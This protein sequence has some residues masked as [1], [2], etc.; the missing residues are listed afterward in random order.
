MTVGIRADAS[1]TF[2]ALTLNGADQLRFGSDNSGA[3]AGFRNRIINGDMRVA[4]RGITTFTAG[5]FPVDRWVVEANVPGGATFNSSQALDGGLSL[6]GPAHIYIQTTAAGAVGAGNFALLSQRMEGL[7]VANF[8]FGTSQAKTITLSFRAFATQNVTM[9]V[10]IRNGGSSRSYVS[11]VA[12]TTT[13][14]SYS[15]VIPGDTTDTWSTDTNTGMTVSFCHSAGTTFQTS[16]LNA[17]QAG[18]FIAANTQTQLFPVLNGAISIGDVQLEVGSI[19]TPFEVRQCGA[20]LALCQ[21]YYWRFVGATGNNSVIGTGVM[22][23]TTTAYI[24]WNMPVTMRI[25]PIVSSLGTIGMYDGS[26]V[27][28]LSGLNND[29]STVDRV[30]RDYT[31]AAA[32]ILGRPALLVVRNGAYIEHNAE[33]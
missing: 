16:T 28:N 31:L 25:V 32:L 21:R 6:V 29:S 22:S 8:K 26:T 1:G 9:S 11:T 24:S 5:G 13:P 2:G 30:S 17:W 19:A 18:N 7:N 10:A 14:T 33:L 12:L 3:L 15:I 4:Q 20:E 23:G 27:A